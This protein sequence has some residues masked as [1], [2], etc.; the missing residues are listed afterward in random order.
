MPKFNMYQ[1][2]HTT[3]IGP[4]GKPVEL[5]IRTY[6]M[7]RRPS[8]ASPRTGSTRRTR[9]PASRSIAVTHRRDPTPRSERHGLAAP[10]AGL[11]EGDRG[12]RR[13]PRVAAVRHHHERG[14]RLHPQG[15]R[16]RAACTGHPGRLR[17]RGAHRGRPPLHR[18][19]GQRPAGA[20]G[21]A[22]STTATSSRSSPRR[23]PAP[24]P[25]RDWLAFVTS[26][27]A[28]NKIKQWF[29]KERRDE[30]IENGKD[31]I[32]K[33]MRKQDLPLQRM[34]S[35]ETLTVVARELRYPDITAL[36]AAVGEG[37]LSAQSVVQK[38][39]QTLGGEAGTSDD[40]AEAATA[41]QAAPANPRRSRRRRQGRERRVD[42][43]R[44]L[45]HAGAGRRDRRFRDPRIGVSRTPGGLRERRVPAARARPDDR[46]RVG[47]DG[48]QHVPRRD[49]GRGSRPQPA[50]V[51]HHPGAV[52][53]ARQHSVGD[54]HDELR[55]D[56]EEPVHLRDGR[57]ETSRPCAEGRPHA[58]KAC[59]TPTG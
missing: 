39:V 15:R 11:A 24:G 47:A 33:A 23:R 31:S 54:G 16:R 50:V 2:L 14:L 55:P 25:S 43:A 51:R 26:A 36:Y 3:V 30:A 48:Q 1:S 41:D 21:V 8:T 46:G 56:R 35:Q 27:R 22:R 57:P 12:S 52:R 13:V 9:T 10:A 28:R 34:L 19:P 45:L 44:P 6:A 20:A 49:P 42:Q 17:L 58:S 40:A 18:R 32:A 7:H 29:S 5:Q 59:S 38:L 37:H 4:S 53:P